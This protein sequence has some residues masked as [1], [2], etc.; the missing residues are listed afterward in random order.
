MFEVSREDTENGVED[1]EE[2]NMVEVGIEDFE[3]STL[4]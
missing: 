4:S 3:I 1:A 2:D